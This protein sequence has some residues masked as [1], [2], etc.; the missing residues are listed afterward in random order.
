VNQQGHPALSAVTSVTVLLNDMNDNAPQFQQEQYSATVPE[1]ATAGTQ[2]V[3]VH[4][5]DVDTGVYGEVRYTR[6]LGQM[7]DSLYLDPHTGQITIS[8]NSH[9][10]DREISPGL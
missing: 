2:V 7:N 4:A 10:F 1:N 5:E 8:T 6:I 9:R 3:Q